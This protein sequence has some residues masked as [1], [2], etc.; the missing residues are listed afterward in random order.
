MG[1]NQISIK[2]YLPSYLI[3]GKRAWR[4]LYW[5]TLY[6][7]N[8]IWLPVKAG[9]PYPYVDKP[10]DCERLL[11]IGGTDHCGDVQPLFYNNTMNVVAQPKVKKCGCESC[12][13]SGLCEDL[14][15]TV[16]TTNV[17]F[18]IN[19]IDYVEKI[20]IKYG[21]NG[22][23][24]EYKETPVKQYN[25]FI[26]DGGDFNNDFNNDYSIGTGGL[27]NFTVIT[28][29]SQRKICHLKTY[30]CGCP[31]DVPENEEL[32]RNHCSCFIPFFGH[33]RREHCEKFLYDT[34]RLDR[35]ECKLSECGTKIYFRPV[36]R[37][38][39]RHDQDHKRIPDFLLVGYQTNGDPKKVNDQIRIP[40]FSI[41]AHWAGT[42][43]Y[44]KKFNAKYSQNERDSA[45]YLFDSECD[46]LI[47][48]LNPLSLQDLADIQ[49][50]PVKW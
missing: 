41:D 37:H 20:W 49:D 8:S 6:V 19:G 22:D 23:I 45:K 36:S 46:N 25:D 11:Y 29:T 48:F 12:D 30:P 15:S 39:H 9:D 13:C 42:F 38:N 5:N 17:L 44:I 26:G 31:M 47:G 43:Y 34:N 28:K 24:L 32:V 3:A 2:K 16:F 40:E 1:L 10:A 4:K 7:T 18:T 14:N 33:R 50:L 27:S 35:G 21:R